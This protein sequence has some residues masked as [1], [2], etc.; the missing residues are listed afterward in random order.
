MVERLQQYQMGHWPLIP[1]ELVANRLQH[2]LRYRA[3]HCCSPPLATTEATCLR[4][5][6]EL[7]MLSAIVIASRQSTDHLQVEDRRCEALPC[8]WALAL[9]DAERNWHIAHCA[10][11]RGALLPMQQATLQLQP[12]SAVR[13]VKMPQREA[14]TDCACIPVRTAAPAR[15]LDELSAKW[16]PLEHTVLRPFPNYPELAAC[17]HP[18]HGQEEKSCSSPSRDGTQA[19]TMLP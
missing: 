9:H 17:A 2:R 14:A 8:K 19:A 1:C 4:P 16:A 3:L 11:V 12:M 7:A 13:D 15:N 10:R 6:G 5:I 18:A